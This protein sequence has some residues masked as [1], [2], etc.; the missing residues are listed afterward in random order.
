MPNIAYV[1]LSDLHLGAANSVLTHLDEHGNRL[2]G[3]GPMFD[4]LLAAVDELTAKSGTNSPPTLIIHGDLF[5]LALTSLEVAATT[6]D[7]F[8]VRAWGDAGGPLFA[9]EAIFV[10]GNHDHHM[11][12]LAREHEFRDDLDAAS[13]GVP[14]MRH[15]TP[16]LHSHLPT[17]ALAPL[18][19]VLAQRA[20]R[21]AGSAID[22]TFRVPYPNFGLVTPARDRAVV[23]THGHYLEPMYRAMSFLH[24]VVTPA[25]PPRLSTDALEAD[26]WAWIDFFWSTMGRSGDTDPE[27][28]AVP[29]LYEMLQHETSVDSIL[30]RVLDDFLPR[31]RSPIRW[32]ERWALT[33]IG[34]R[35]AGKVIERERMHP[36]LLSRAATDGLTNYLIGPVHE[37][38]MTE[39]GQLPDHVDLVF[40][41][42]HKPFARPATAAGFASPV[43]THNTG[44]WVVDGT[45]PEPMKGASIVLITD[46]LEVVDV[47]VYHQGSASNLSRASVTPINGIAGPGSEPTPLRDWLTSTGIDHTSPVWTHLA[48][49]AATT[50]TQ[51]R[52][53][54]A[55]RIA[56]GTKAVR[57]EPPVGPRGW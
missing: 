54:L 29:V 28:A 52:A 34:H 33:R 21:E 4:A 53:Q 3:I 24:N 12:E 31:R 23:V 14:E 40:G 27:G 18:V 7:D 42:T 55:Q 44:G 30:D 16:M 15:I 22:V 5:E 13:T 20:L 46:E 48:D 9:S 50:V 56:A 43:I 32:I 8:V 1:C 37:Q 36:A 38:L 10:P 45:D 41:H 51:R 35:I 26:N 6:F 2:P 11:W 49:V 25:R 19:Q 57:D 47:N 17:D 39:V